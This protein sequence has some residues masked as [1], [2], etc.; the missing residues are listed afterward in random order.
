MQLPVVTWR[1]RYIVYLLKGLLAEPRELEGSIMREREEGDGGGG[2]R[3]R[4]KASY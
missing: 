2:E 4:E 3:A 1:R